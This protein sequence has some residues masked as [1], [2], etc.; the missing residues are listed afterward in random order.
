MM[1]KDG[2]S[3]FLSD[4][5]KKYNK[6]IQFVMFLKLPG[7]QAGMVFSR[8]S[9]RSHEILIDDRKMP[10]VY[11]I[12]HTLFH[13]IAHVVLSHFDYSSNEFIVTIEE[14]EKEA[15]IWAF[16]EIGIYDE[17]GSIKEGEMVCFKCL[18]S[19]IRTCMKKI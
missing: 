19:R 8:K 1:Q 13:E 16:Q 11:H 4:I 12:F 10:C 7:N 17:V 6:N 5:A 18:Q 2:I 14:Q 3:P 9:F 15:D